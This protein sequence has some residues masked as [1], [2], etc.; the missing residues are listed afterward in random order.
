[1]IV[2]D[3][4][5]RAFTGADEGDSL[6]GMLQHGVERAVRQFVGWEL[7]RATYTRYYPRS[8]PGGDTDPFVVGQ[9]SIA[10]LGGL[11]EVLQLDHMYV[12]N[13]D[14]SV[15]EQSEAYYGQGSDADWS[16]NQ[17]TKGESWVLD[18]ADGQVSESGQLIRLDGT[19][20]KQRGSVKVTYTAG[21]TASELL[22]TKSGVESYTDA[23]D[24]RMAVLLALGKAYSQA[25]MHQH[26]GDPKRPS[27]L[28]T[29]E[30]ITGYSY[31]LHPEVAAMMSGLADSLP[32]ECH[33]LLH[34]YKRYANPL[35]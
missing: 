21:F 24:I 3:T 29:S 10:S 9:G 19:W 23:S 34:K 17:L 16:S 27:G 1:M 35:G 15:Y 12:L 25:K 22:G 7:E 30:S 11:S 18:T 32:L 31:S 6:L 13:S 33:R 2:S 8:D 14:L 28:I 5:A 20:P 4:D 26:S